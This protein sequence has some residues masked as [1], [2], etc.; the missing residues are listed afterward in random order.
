MVVKI[1]RPKIKHAIKRDIALMKCCASL[2]RP[3]ISGSERLRLPDVIAEFEHSI[4]H[5][6]DLMRE[7]GNAS[8]IRRTYLNSRQLYVPKVYWDLSS[9]QVLTL[10][11]IHGINIGNVKALHDAG[12]NMRK[13]A[14]TGIEI[15]FSGIKRSVFSCRYASW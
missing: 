7:A 9:K 12:V 8:Q 11:R 14:E 6:L 13:L 3:L 1:L 10:E 15:F 4:L 5:E 2:L